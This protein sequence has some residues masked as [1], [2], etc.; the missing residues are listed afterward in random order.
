MKFVASCNESNDNNCKGDGAGHGGG[1][2][3]QRDM[4]IVMMLAMPM[5]ATILRIV[6]AKAFGAGD[7]DDNS[8]DN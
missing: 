5:P 8:D 1:D 7:L 2:R 4:M 3:N 6:T